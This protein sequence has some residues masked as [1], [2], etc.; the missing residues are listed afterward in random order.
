MKKVWIYPHSSLNI[1]FQITKY[2]KSTNFFNNFRTAA[3]EKPNSRLIS[4]SFLTSKSSRLHNVNRNWNSRNTNQL[5]NC[6]VLIIC[7][8]AVI[9]WCLYNCGGWLLLNWYR[10]SN[11]YQ[12][13]ENLIMSHVLCLAVCLA[14]WAHA[15]WRKKKPSKSLASDVVIR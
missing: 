6:F 11:V 4:F 13:M 9:H 3:Y 7:W 2:L 12:L 14:L 5:T 10:A 8:R 1:M 15:S